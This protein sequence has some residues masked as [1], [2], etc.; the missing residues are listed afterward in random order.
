MR[1]LA[2]FVDVLID[3][4]AS[5]CTPC[6]AEMPKLKTAQE[7]YGDKGLQIVGVSLDGNERK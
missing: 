3:F 5:W 6:I 2:D 4:W 1:C 7:L